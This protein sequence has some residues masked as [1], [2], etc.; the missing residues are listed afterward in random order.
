MKK[1]LFLL[2]S[3]SPLLIKAQAFSTG[4]FGEKNNGMGGTG[5][6]LALDAFGSNPGSISFINGNSIGIGGATAVT[7]TAY[8]DA[9]NNSLSRTKNGVGTP[10][11]AAYVFGIKDSSAS[12]LLSRFKFAIGA[13][14]PYGGQSRW[15]KDWTG[16]YSIVDKNLKSLAIAPVVS[17]K[18]N[19]QLS[20]GAA[21][22][23]SQ[24]TL[25]IENA[26]PVD[27][28]ANVV[29]DFKLR[30]FG[31]GGGVFYTP[32]E[33][34]SLGLSY[35][36][37]VNNKSFSGKATFTVPSSL[38]DQFP[39]GDVSTKSSVPQIISIGAGYKVN[40]K[41]IL[42]FDVNYSFWNCFDSTIF[43][44][45]NVDSN[46]AISTIRIPNLY[47][48]TI[49]IRMGAQ[50]K[51]TDKIYSRAGLSYEQTPVPSDYVYPE[52]PDADRINITAGGSY[53][54]NKHFTIDLSYRFINLMKRKS[55]NLHSNM[56]GTY[57]TYG[58]VT[59]VSV[60]YNF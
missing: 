41:L 28:D 38:S 32:T 35:I 36:S 16:K 40:D 10:F 33:K 4:Y 42:A 19:Q 13:A 11:H 45:K 23:Y 15:E 8:L 21:F 26:I 52:T 22:A 2:V 20:F 5:T 17:F 24:S 58:H 49:S 29:M 27:P 14:T 54:I 59:G 48:N 7:N 31:F 39:T 43:V 3:L 51:I 46:S 50:Y 1:I 47:K 55:T 57:K 18:I 53:I 12:S 56:T 44:F 6:G 34:L 60:I 37:Q 25:H 30:G 9:N